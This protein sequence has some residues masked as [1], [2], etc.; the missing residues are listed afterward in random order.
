[1]GGFWTGLLQWIINALGAALI[2]VIDWFPP[3][4]FGSPTT[5]PDAVNLGWVTWLLDFPTW[6]AHLTTIL[7]CF[8]TYYG[9]KVA[10]RWLKMVR[11]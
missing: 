9:I 10:A 4:P 8:I 6:I 11:N 2:W 5:P 7:S 1:M 3:S